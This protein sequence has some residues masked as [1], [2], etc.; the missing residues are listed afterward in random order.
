MSI[1]IRLIYRFLLT[2]VLGVVLGI[3]TMG[4]IFF[5][6]WFIPSSEFWLSMFVVVFSLVLS[7]QGIIT[8]MW[9]LY[10][11]ENPSKAEGYKSPVKFSLPGYT[12]SALIPARNEKKVIGDTIRAVSDINYPEELKETIV[13]CRSDDGET[14]SEINKTIKSLGKKNIRLLIFDDLP[15]NKP[16]SLNI[17]LKNARNQV[18]TVFDAEDQPNQD[19]YNIVN[20]LMTSEY[21]DVVQSGVQLM[22]YRSHWFS[23]IN[24]L[25]YF[26]WFKSGL[27]FFS[28]VGNVTPLGGNTV[29]FKKGYLEKIGG[30]DESCLTEDADVGIRLVRHGAKVRIVYDEQ[31]V[32]REET[33]GSVEAFIKQRTRWNHGFLQ[34]LMKGDWKDLPQARQK[35]VALYT[36][37]APMLQVGFLFYLPLGVWIATHYKLPVIVSIFSFI[38]TYIFLLQIAV[39]FVG[40]REFAKTYGLKYSFWDSLKILIVFLPYQI[41]LTIA[42]IRAILRL[43]YK[44]NSWEKTSHNNAHRELSERILSTY[45]YAKNYI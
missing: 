23:S 16:H 31:H 32:T 13:L 17:G 6:D 14:I 35:I 36:L 21:V 41:M 38:P 28:R 19:I 44:Q 20:T 15:I 33:P 39:F 26:F 40:I 11:W 18:I 5:G 45:I 29:F 4:L 25:E 43:V 8:L 7:F 27:H 2:F 30:W 3:S 24:V 42:S 37:I 22:N 10:A 9:M 34:V 1:S 12:F